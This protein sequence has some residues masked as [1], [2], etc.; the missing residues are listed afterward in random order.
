MSPDLILAPADAAFVDAA[1]RPVSLPTPAPVVPTPEPELGHVVALLTAQ[2]GSL[3][4]AV[5]AMQERERWYNRRRLATTE[6]QLAVTRQITIP[7]LLE[8][9][10]LAEG[11][12]Q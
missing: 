3:T 8:R 2:V 1:T 6:Q 12:A 11:Q 9:I 10:R 7:Q 4:T 5:Q